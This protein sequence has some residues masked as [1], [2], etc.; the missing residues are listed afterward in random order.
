M[1]VDYLRVAL[2]EDAQLVGVPEPDLYERLRER[3]QRSDRRRLAF[4]ASGLVALLVGIAIPLSLIRLR[5]A[6]ESAEVANPSGV[7]GHLGLPTR[8][9]LG[10]DQAFI[11]EVLQLPWDASGV[12]P[13]PQTR[14]VAFAGD[15][16]DQRWALV[17]GSQNDGTVVGMW[18]FAWAGADA[19]S[20]RP[21]DQLFRVSPDQPVVATRG[22][23][24]ESPVVVI[25]APGDLVEVSWHTDIDNEGTISRTFEPLDTVNG[26]AITSIEGTGDCTICG[27][28]IAVSRSGQLLF[29]GSPMPQGGTFASPGLDSIEFADP[30]GFG[31]LV[32]DP[33][34]IANAFAGLAAP[35]GF[36]INQLSPVL[37][38]AGQIPGTTGWETTGIVV[39]ITLPS[40]ASAVATSVYTKRV[41]QDGWMLSTDSR[42]YV[43]PPGLLDAGLALRLEAPTGRLPTPSGPGEATV[44]SL[45]ILAPQE[46]NVARPLGPGG[47]VVS[48]DIP[49][50]DGL[51]LVPYPE[52]TV[53]LA[54]EGPGAGSSTAEVGYGDMTSRYA[55]DGPGYIG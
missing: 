34:W 4:V 14:H 6:N 15:L 46:F 16:L 33:V 13:R 32:P 40:G 2:R 22:G 30:R 27:L 45:L 20:L 12:I 51:A 43:S 48:S 37:L 26:V 7:Q 36:P 31:G 1:D 54:L 18:F 24:S 39:A 49:L 41:E 47:V 38:Y 28:S 52:P 50:N 42:I 55:D 10:A 21:A 23:A 8:G 53:R 25:T 3:R 35:L 9:N 29:R 11:E 5:A 44:V 17:V 19:K